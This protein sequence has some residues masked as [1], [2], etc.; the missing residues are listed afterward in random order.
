VVKKVVWDFRN[1][2]KETA[3]ETKFRKANLVSLASHDE[4]LSFEKQT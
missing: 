2:A 3:K 4:K 1:G